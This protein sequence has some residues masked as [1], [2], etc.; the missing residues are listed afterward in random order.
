M[1]RRDLLKLFGVG[2]AIVP[3]IGGVPEVQAKA[4]LVDLPHIIAAPAPQ[5]IKPGS[6]SELMG[7]YDVWLTAR[8]QKTGHV[9]T[10]RCSA[11]LMNAQI[12]VVDVTSLGS[13]RGF[14][15]F[16]PGPLHLTFEATGEPIVVE[17]R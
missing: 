13:S 15:E 9:M 6:W 7:G 16:K 11:F 12:E 14:R 10:M 1:N 4:L 17:N 3:V 5:I 2:S 8:E